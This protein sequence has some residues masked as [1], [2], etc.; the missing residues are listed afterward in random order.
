MSVTPS[1]F[2]FAYLFFCKH[3]TGRRNPRGALLSSFLKGIQTPPTR[4]NLQHTSLLP[5]WFLFPQSRKHPT[6]HTSSPDEPPGK[7][8]FSHLFLLLS[9]MSR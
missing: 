4:R 3:T 7:N 6:Q 8:P 2:F 1:R 9:L 5:T